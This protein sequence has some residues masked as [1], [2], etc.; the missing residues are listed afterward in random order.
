MSL[1]YLDPRCAVEVWQHQHVD[2]L[3]ARSWLESAEALQ[4]ISSYLGGAEKKETRAP[5]AS[6]G[7]TAKDQVTPE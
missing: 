3:R 1:V 2:K 7:A 4:S 5:Q 6:G